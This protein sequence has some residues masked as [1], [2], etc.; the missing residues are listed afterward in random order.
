MLTSYLAQIQINTGNNAAQGILERSLNIS[1]ET[2]ESWNRLWDLTVSPDSVLWQALTD[3][4][5][6][7]AVMSILYL[8]IKEVNADS[9]TYRRLVTIVQLPLFVILFL[10]GNGKILADT[11]MA[12]RQ[13]ALYWLSQV[14]NLTIADISI[15]EAIQ[16]IQNTTVANGRAREIFSECLEQTGLQL[17]ECVQDPV[18][19]Q[20]AQELL[21]NL[22]QGNSVPLQGNILER[23]VSGVFEGYVNIA[24]QTPIKVIE[25]F[26]AVLQWAFMNGV[27]A[28]LLLAALF[29]PV[30][31]GF[32][33][34]PSAGPTIF[35]WFSGYVAL[36]LMQLGYVIIVGFSAMVLALSENS[37]QNF[38][39]LYTDIAFLTFLAI[40]APIM[41]MAISKGMGDGIFA[42]INR[43]AIAGIK[44][45]ATIIKMGFASD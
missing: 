24:I 19:T 1:Q 27:E 36:F 45:S 8:T 5:T 37:S 6:F 25:F 32:S 20:Q 22:G 12:M 31:V 17:Q 16:K 23:V 21:Q 29:A 30:A 18:K 3:I 9:L 10:A 34:I 39:S 38:G 11:V 40:F 13:I 42:A 35:K 26:M 15:S 33:M 41:A 7:L 44:F 28:A 4:G 14:L 43:S 2:F